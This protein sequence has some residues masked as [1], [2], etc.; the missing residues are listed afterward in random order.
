MES[1]MKN[2]HNSEAKFINLL[3]ML[4]Y[5]HT[6]LDFRKSESHDTMCINI[7]KCLKENLRQCYLI[8]YPLV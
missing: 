3:L 8:L 6:H 4:H 1:Y 7:Y 2:I 5:T